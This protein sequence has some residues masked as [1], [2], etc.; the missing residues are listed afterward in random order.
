MTANTPTSAAGYPLR[1]D[2]TL[3]STEEF[4]AR[5]VHRQ[6]EKIATGLEQ[7][8]LSIREESAHLTDPRGATRPYID[9]A[10]SITH[11]IAN[12]LPNLPLGALL[13]A[14]AEAEI[15][16]AHDTEDQP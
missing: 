7:A 4:L 8:A 9:A 10:K 1:A 12:L 16:R 3:V 6:I 13:T 2:G 15:M 5:D 14:A 11:T